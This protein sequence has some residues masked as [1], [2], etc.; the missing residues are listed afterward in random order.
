M[1]VAWFPGIAFQPHVIC[2]HRE[3][4]DKLKKCKN[5]PR[6]LQVEQYLLC[7]REEPLLPAWCGPEGFFAPGGEGKEFESCLFVHKD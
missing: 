5:D 3:Q 4:L 6:G 7:G 2:A 1:I